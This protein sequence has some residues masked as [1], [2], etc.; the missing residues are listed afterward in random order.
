M[1]ILINP[2]RALLGAIAV[3]AVLSGSGPLV[4]NAHAGTYLAWQCAAAHGGPGNNDVG[5]NNGG[6]ATGG[7]GYT[8]RNDCWSGSVP[9]GFP[10][11]FGHQAFQ[12]AVTGSYKAFDVIAPG[13]T[14]FLSGSVEGN[15]FGIHG[16]EPLISVGNGSSLSTVAS[17]NAAGGAAGVNYRVER[18]LRKYD[19]TRR[20]DGLRERERLV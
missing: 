1:T 10:Y 12:G 2:R 5:N 13:G 8:S 19:A 18:P 4:S 9:N 14:R 20:L 15:L 16:H 3:A 7:A 17:N 11:S 6:N